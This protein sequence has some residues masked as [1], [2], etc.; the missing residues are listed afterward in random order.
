MVGR[1]R[2]SLTVLPSQAHH[3]EAT[4]IL[5]LKQEARPRRLPSPG[6]ALNQAAFRTSVH[7]TWMP[8]MA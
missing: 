1:L 4:G 8:L 5:Y 7:S 2:C 6:L 3:A